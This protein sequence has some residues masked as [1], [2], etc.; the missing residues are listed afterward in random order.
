[1]KS[2]NPFGLCEHRWS[3]IAAQLPGRTDNDIKNYWNTRLKKKLL[4]KHRKEQQSRNS[5]GNN[6][7]IVKQESNNRVTNIGNEYSL[8]SFVQENSTT[9]QHPYL[10]QV[11]LPMPPPTFS[12][13]N[14]GSCFNDQDSIKKLLIKLGGRF[15]SDYHHNPSTTT[16]DGLNLEFS[17]NATHVGSSSSSSSCSSCVVGNVNNNNNQVQLVQGESSGQYF[18]LVQGQGNFNSEIEMVSTTNNFQQRFDGLEFFYGEE[19][20]DNKIIGS[21]STTQI[22]DPVDSNY[23]GYKV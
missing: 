3:I 6:G 4:G 22:Y 14:Q 19:M 20:I 21:S 9:Q 13:T 10:P 2:E 8:S 5:K 7:V 23:Q 12:Y 11:M 15:S 18:D 16:F 1:M 17:S